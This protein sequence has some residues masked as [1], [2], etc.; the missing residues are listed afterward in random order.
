MLINRSIYITKIGGVLCGILLIL[1][2]WHDTTYED[3]VNFGNHHAVE[4]SSYVLEK[5][6]VNDVVL[7]G[8]RH[9]QKRILEFVSGMLPGLCEAGV[10]HLG[11][12][13]ASDQQE[14]IDFYMRNG[15]G[16]A[17]INMHHSI[18]CPA[19][20][21]LLKTIREFEQKNMLKAVALDLPTSLYESHWNRDEWMARSICSILNKQPDAKI[22]VIVGNLHALKDI[23]WNEYVPNKSGVIRRY[24][25]QSNPDLKV[26]SICQCISNVSNENNL[27]SYYKKDLMGIAFDCAGR[28][29]D[30]DLNVLEAVA[31]KSM[32]AHEI[33]DGLVIYWK[34]NRNI[35]DI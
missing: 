8:T 1:F 27:S 34:E 33:T 2:L 9:K 19:Y 30:I 7:L 20:R 10:S 13:I 23:V 31:A 29:S 28:F 6:K 5:F 21:D 25:Y 4:P 17:K 15:I 32:K 11:L 3:I 14:Y 26:F 18:D 22:L 16:I 35:D 12:E 24:L